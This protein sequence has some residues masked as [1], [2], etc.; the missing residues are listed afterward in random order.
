MNMPN[1]RP[2]RRSS[3]RNRPV[4]NAVGLR[5]LAAIGSAVA[6][7]LMKRDLLFVIERLL[8]LMDEARIGMLA[9]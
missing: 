2:N 9:T 1:G 4:A 8:L 7:R 6:V 3:A 5:V